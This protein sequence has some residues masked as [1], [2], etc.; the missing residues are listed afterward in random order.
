MNSKSEYC[1][2]E[3]RFIVSGQQNSKIKLLYIKDILE[4]YSDE[5]NV[6]NSAEILS[7]LEFLYGIQCERK[8]LYND[9]DVLESYGV[10]VIRTR[11]PR[12]GFFVG[13]RQ[14]ELAEIRLLCDAVQAADFISKAKTKRLI[15]RI[16]SFA[17]VH[18]AA[19]LKK[20]IYIDS[21]I[22]CENEKIYYFIDMLDSAI[23]NEKKVKISY[24]RRV[25]GDKFAAAKTLREFVISPYS[26]IWS[27]DRYYL[28]A[29]NAK[30]DNLMNL[31]VDRIADVE[32]LSEKARH[33][34]EVCAYKNRFDAADYV[35]KTFN[36]FTGNEEVIE[37]EC[38][39]GVLEEML[40]RFGEN[41]TL[42]KCGEDTFSLRTNAFINDGLVSW[43]MQFGD[44]I[45][46]ISPQRLGDMVTEK[47]KRICELYAHAK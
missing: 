35:R 18:Q 43:I 30:Y 33:F 23:K 16:E 1:E 8:S 41:I 5:N 36:M 14:F 31:R 6:M 7:K 42:R 47:A 21:R 37:L 46:V 28:V 4:K 3:G 12:N 11:T 34:S 10:D 22:K 26:M 9:I 20:Q 17:S 38:N 13:A 40:D 24:A 25:L 44:G 2:S 19:A 27:N 32:V 45:K 15:E 29:N 39:N